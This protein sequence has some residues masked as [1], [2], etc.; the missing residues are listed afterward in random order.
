M[1]RISYPKLHFGFKTI[2]Y[3][4]KTFLIGRKRDLDEH[5]LTEPLEEHKS[6]NLGERLAKNW[7]KEVAYTARRKGQASLARALIK[8]FKWDITLYGIM[9]FLMEICFRLPQPIFIGLFIRYFNPKN[10]NSKDPQY[11]PT[12]IMRVFHYFSSNQSRIS[13]KEAF[14]FAACI[15]LCSLMTIGIFHP[16]IMATL[17]IGMRIRVACCSLIYRKVLRIKLTA[18]GGKTVGNTVNLMSNDV[19]RFDNAPLFLHYLWIAPLQASLITFF[20]Y[21]EMGVASFY[22][23]MALLVVGP[24]QVLLSFATAYLR[25]K[26]GNR[27]DERVRHMN[28][29]I[30][31]IQ[32]IKMYAWE[33]AFLKVISKLRKR[34]LKMLVLTSYIRGLTMSFLMITA[35]IGIFLTVVSFVFL[36]NDVTAEQVFVIGG[37]Y[38]IIRISCTVYFPLGL[39]AV[40]EA[41]VSIKRIQTFLLTDETT[42]GDYTVLDPCRNTEIYK[43]HNRFK[44]IPFRK[45]RLSKMS[46]VTSS[47]QTIDDSRTPR[48]TIFRGI[49]KYGEAVCLENIN[50][51]ITEGQLIAIVGTVG[52]GKSCLLNLILGELKLF[53]GKIK[54]NGTVSYAS[55]EPWLFAGSV[56]QNI[57]FGKELDMDRYHKTIRVCALKRDFSLL[58]YGDRTIVGERGISLSGG[59]RA[60]INLARAVYKE[61]DIY[62]FD[63]PLSAVDIQVGQQLFQECILRYLKG[64]IVILV[65]HQLQ[66]LRRADRIIILNEGTI[67][68]QGTYDEIKRSGVSFALLLEEATQIT[69]GPTE[70]EKE[71][72]RV[73]KAI[74][75]T[76]A[77]FNSAIDI[78]G[79]KSGPLLFAEMRT[80][81]AVALGNYKEY[82]LAGG[83]CCG[84]LLLCILFIGAQFLGS[85]GDYFL[86]QWVYLEELRSHYGS[87]KVAG[88][89]DKLDRKAC[90]EI[91]SIIITTTIV[92][93]IFRSLYFFS[94][95]MRSSYILHNRMFQSIILAAMR[96]FNQNT[97]GRIL[98]RFSKDLGQVDE[99]LPNAFIDTVQITLSLFG[100]LA[101]VCIINVWFLIPVTVMLILFYILRKFYLKTSRS[102]KRLEG[103][104]K[105]PV[106]AHLNATLQGLPTIRINNAEKNLVAEF[107]NL[108]DIHSS[109]WFMFLY[110]SR[111][112]SFWLDW[113]TALF[114]GVVTFT[115]VAQ[116]SNFPGS[117]VGL[118]ITQAIS[119][120]GLI[121]WG[122]RQSAELENQMTSV[123]RVLEFTRIEH[124]P[125]LESAPDK[126]P[127]A[128]W[129]KRGQ[130][131]FVNTSTRY[132]PLDPPV[133]KEL[134][135]T[136][137]PEQKVGIVG[138]TGAG[139]SSLIVTLFRL[140]YFEGEVYID[141]V[142]ISVLGL[143]DLRR[144]ISIIPQE[145]VLF[146]GT[147]RYNLDPFN[148]FDDSQMLSALIDVEDKDAI[149]KGY[150]CLNK[151]MTE[152]GQNVS[153]GQRQMICLARAILRNNKI[154]VMDEATANMDAHTDKLI[155]KTIRSK[156][157]KCTV[158]TIAH[159]L[160]TVMDSDK[161]L[162]MD[163]GEA[164]EFDHPYILLQDP[165]GY[166]TELVRKTGA[167]TAAFLT[168]TA[169][170]NYMQRE[171]KQK[172]VEKDDGNESSFSISDLD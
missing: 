33:N 89:W 18:L 39:N 57:V 10:I 50:T 35:R 166:L 64:K 83:N 69:A 62:L 12:F 169:K 26:A 94:I 156:F 41:K 7:S 15:M 117:S 55:Q 68:I 170:Q 51:E 16:C 97:S 81:G 73:L 66:Y 67:Q 103:I 145:P 85:G 152:G 60:R 23:M 157:A 11:S 90:I 53:S 167:G 160:H 159:R 8:T 88:F 164:V 79:L 1:V 153:V 47:I 161:I 17:H 20:I 19:N 13:Q 147:L 36:D 141:H 155:Q 95:C 137:L 100:A 40:A 77:A 130:I 165:K 143:H 84:L 27:T 70:Q 142:D 138:R 3:S 104:T 86:C 34:E 29:I 92:I 150:E 93:V 125:D 102:V 98:N 80:M 132:N 148:E 114:I 127:P 118:V 119:L 28:E 52:A 82:F 162:V 37:Y 45:V 61:S 43:E 5:D 22:G 131:E 106:F 9:L 140:A 6:S 59:Q 139:K 49:A 146:N 144:K 54:V 78:E 123:E 133:L 113:I 115:C 48:V 168:K 2:R 32:V 24:V 14:F 101:V 121:Q 71:V 135:L 120:T 126:K 151:V 172:I 63:D 75:I 44:R 21:M 128:S 58:P 99:L 76:S 38:L 122:M 112:F 171:A 107:D 87:A 105:S 31:A 72:D 56:R 149:Y 111:A 96:F 65:T 116:P 30:Q 158:L 25:V 163:A 108:Q 109:A 124:E 134:N 91:Y 4:L 154:L 136:I 46:S 74:S 129:P 110:T 42:V